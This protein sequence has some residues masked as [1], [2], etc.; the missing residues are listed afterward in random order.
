MRYIDLSKLTFPDGWKDRAK[1]AKEAV[2]DDIKKINSRS[3]IWSELKEYLEKLSFEK[4]WYCE[5]RQIRSDNNVDHFRPKGRVS[6]TEPKHTGYTWL[7]F[8]Y[9][10]YR[11]ACTFCNSKRKNLDTD[12]TE[13]KGD[14]FPLVDE[15]KRAYSK[16]DK[17][18][19]EEPI[20]L[21]PCS[22][23]DVKLLDFDSDE[24][25]P[26]PKANI[27][28]IKRKRVEQSIKIYHLDHPKLNRDRNNLALEIKE[29]I[30]EINNYLDKYPNMEISESLQKDLLKFISVESELSRFSLCVLKQNRHNE[31][32]EDL[33]GI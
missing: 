26:C 19:L 2:G 7:A 29:K 6:N 13:G 24:G 23:N 12:E 25:T 32:I 5:C 9:K 10:N 16:S 15:K 31:W 27:D 21:D 8:D 33:L 30:E 17:I 11:Y 14:D 3:Y 1:K 4:C 22:I 20:L 18:G 28:T